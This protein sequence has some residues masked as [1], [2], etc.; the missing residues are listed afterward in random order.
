MK[1][2]ADE[3]NDLIRA[4][5]QDFAAYFVPGSVLVYAGDT[6]KKWSDFD[7]SLLA[8][9]NVDVDLHCKMPDVLLHFVEKNWLLLIESVTSHGPIDGMRR[10][11]LARLFAGSTTGLI[12]VTVFPSRA[13]MSRYLGKIAW[14]TEVWCASDPTHLIHFNGVRFLG[15]HNAP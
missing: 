15:P 8:R 6:D 5:I 7:A 13:I 11:E 10:D 9:L 3:H 14:E 12:F 4:T 2:T 1:F